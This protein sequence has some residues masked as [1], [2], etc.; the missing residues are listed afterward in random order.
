ML[1]LNNLGLIHIPCDILYTQWNQFVTAFERQRCNTLIMLCKYIHYIAYDINRLGSSL[2]HF[3]SFRNVKC[4][5]MESLG[6]EGREGL[7]S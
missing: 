2:F 4:V 6:G 3:Q 5:W 1:C 7:I